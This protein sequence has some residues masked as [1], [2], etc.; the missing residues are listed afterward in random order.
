ML[1]IEAMHLLVRLLVVL[2]VAFER[3]T[4]S[5][6]ISRTRCLIS[7]PCT[8]RCV[9][10]W[11]ADQWLPTFRL[12]NEDLEGKMDQA[13]EMMLVCFVGCMQDIDNLEAH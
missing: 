6:R 12:S 5:M 13:V 7:R 3:L 11:Y 1:D 10:W 8:C 2:L 9:S 4:N